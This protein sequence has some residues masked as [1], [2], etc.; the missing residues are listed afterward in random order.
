MKGKEFLAQVLREPSFSKLHPQVAAFL[1]DYLVHEKVRK[2]DGHYVVNTHFPPYP[3]GAFVNMATQFSAIGEVAQRSLFSVTLAVTN[4]C[5][6]HCWHCYNAGRSQEDVPLST[7]R[8]VVQDLQDLDV[9]HVTLTGGEPLL[10]SSLAEI[11]G[12]FD[13][14]TYLT[15]NTTGAG[16]TPERARALKDSG[17]FALGVSLDSAAPAEHDRMRGTEG[18]FRTAV[19]ALEVASEA[20]LYPYVIAVSTHELLQ[21]ERFYGFM[22]FAAECGAQE[23]HLLEPSATGKL[24]G[25]TDVLLDQEERQRTLQFQREV[26][27]REDLPILS[28]FLY[29]ESP[30]AFGCGAGLT[31]LYIDGSG[32]VCPCNLVPLSFGNVTRE[33]LLEILERMGIHFRKPRTCCVGR[34]LS[35][36]SCGGQVP[37]SPE[38]SREICEKHLPKQHG[39]PRFFQVRAEAKGDVGPQEL[40]SAYNRIHADYD[41]FWLK[42]AGKPVEQLVD[43]CP[44]NGT[45]RVFEAGCGTG[46]ATALIA[47]RLR[48]PG[49]LRAVDLSEGMLAEARARMQS[50]GIGNIQFVAGDALEALKREAPFDVVFSSWV[51]GYIPL[52]AF[53]T[54]S[55]RALRSGGHVAFIVHKENS[56][57]EHLDI[58]RELVARDPGVLKKRVAFDFPRDMEHLRSELQTAG[59]EIE[60]LWDGK[61]T[62]RYNTSEEVLDHLLKSG[63][64]TAFH[65]AVDPHRRTALEQEFLQI[66]NDRRGANTTHAVVHDYISC[67]ARKP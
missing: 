17:L 36:H 50:R 15:L 22:R 37:R 25:R 38:A 26:A 62:F 54:R 65:D 51:L 44:L 1:Q 56:P 2:F 8:K 16:L 21:R 64:G 40:K 60:R 49:T 43:R 33:P 67:V 34:T 10:R 41:A 57:R 45:E 53:F 19:K 59:F 55:N 63:A 32:E 7:L 14:S 9:V 42:E 58:F 39:V 52:K 20:G 61:V 47:E 11:V 35:R 30:E 24:A 6:Y 66:L 18:A 5:P 27:A 23:V 13:D 4:R 46:F 48:E 31:H 29:L 3:S 12:A 28:S